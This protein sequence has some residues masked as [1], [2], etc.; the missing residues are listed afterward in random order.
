[1]TV[2]EAPWEAL[3]SSFRST[4]TKLTTRFGGTR[5][6]V[7]L[8]NEGESG[9]DIWAMRGRKRELYVLCRTVRIQRLAGVAQQ[10][11]TCLL[12]KKALTRIRHQSIAIAVG[13]RSVLEL[14]PYR[15]GLTWI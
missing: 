9:N 8:Q 14:Y 11:S 1:M 4:T 10:R 2:I 6:F 15:P 3:V 7:R 13:V 12:C 5:P